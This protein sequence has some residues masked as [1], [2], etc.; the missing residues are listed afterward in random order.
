MGDYF[1]V[2]GE[3]KAVRLPRKMVGTG[4]H[5]GFGFVDY[6]TKSDA[7][8]A[9]EALC[10]STHLYG[11]RLVLEWAAPEESVEELRKRTAQ[12]FTEDRQPKQSRKSVLEMDLS[13]KDE[14]DE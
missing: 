11:R 4:P 13:N 14:G 2:F 7:K 1:R 8:R 3:L 6:V 5:R 10:Q 9:F 12:H